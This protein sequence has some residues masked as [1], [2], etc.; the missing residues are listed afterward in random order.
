[1]CTHCRSAAGYEHAQVVF[2]ALVFV[3]VQFGYVTLHREQVD[4]IWLNPDWGKEISATKSP[5]K[6]NMDMISCLSAL[7]GW[8]NVY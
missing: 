1:M 4:K 6:P 5:K 8:E 3:R 2:Q 7:P